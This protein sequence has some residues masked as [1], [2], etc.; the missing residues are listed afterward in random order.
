[1]KRI[2][3][4]DPELLDLVEDRES[5]DT[6]PELITRVNEALEKLEPELR[7]L[8]KMRY[9]DGA[10][11]RHIAGAL[12]KSEN[13]ITGLLYEAKRQ[14][15]IL[16]AD[17]VRKRWGVESSG[18]CRICAHPKRAVIEKILSTRKRSESWRAING[19]IFEAVGESFQPPQILRAHL[20][21]MNKKRGRRDER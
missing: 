11:I 20:R 3:Y 5:P 1:M 16:L 6:D 19:R 17:F 7:R 14:M 21:H 4:L 8:L 15:K 2:I 9:Y 10:R 12:N 18:I 13:E